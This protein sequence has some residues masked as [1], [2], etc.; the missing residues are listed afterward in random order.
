MVERYYQDGTEPTVLPHMSDKPV[1]RCC[2]GY[3]CLQGRQV[4]PHPEYCVA[5]DDWAVVEEDDK[6]SMGAAV[7]DGLMVLALVAAVLAVIWLALAP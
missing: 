6:P 1:V 7:R 5:I 3:A 2:R 4:C